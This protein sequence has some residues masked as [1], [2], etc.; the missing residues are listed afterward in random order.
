[1]SASSR[2][3]SRGQVWARSHARR[4]SRGAFSATK[5]RSWRRSSAMWSGSSRAVSLHH[6]PVKLGL[7]LLD[8]GRDRLAP[9]GGH[10]GEDFVGDGGVRH[11]RGQRLQREVGDGL[12]PAHRPARVGEDLGDDLGDPGVELVGGDDVVD[13]ADFGGALA[14][15][16]ISPVIRNSLARAKPM[17]C[18]QITAPPSPATSPTLTCGSPMTAVSA[19]TMT[20][21]SS[22]IVAPSPAAAPFRRQMIGFSISSSDETMRLASGAMARNVR[23]S[24]MCCWNQAMSPPAQKARPAPVSTIDVAV[25]IVLR[26]L[27][28]ARQFV[29]HGGVDGVDGRRPGERDGQDARVAGEAQARVLSECRHYR[30][31]RYAGRG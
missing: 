10:V 2:N 15:D 26:V 1:M 31:S 4:F 6:S 7:A 19:A 13:E 9:V 17:S 24:S 23:G 20:S 3:R 27:K 12:G 29:V 21:H 22:A 5:R 18:G 16:S 30:S 28:H 11:L 25:R 8:E 14:A